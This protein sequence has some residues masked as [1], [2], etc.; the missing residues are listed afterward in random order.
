MTKMNLTKIQKNALTS[1]LPLISFE[2]HKALDEE[3]G[4]TFQDSVDMFGDMIFRFNDMEK[5][6]E[7]GNQIWRNGN[8]I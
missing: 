1:S 6:W 2:I 3:A 8:Q 4:L 7:D 5:N